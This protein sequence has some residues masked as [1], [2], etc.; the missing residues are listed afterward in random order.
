MFIILILRGEAAGEAST[1][2]VSRV[3]HGLRNLQVSC[4]VL[5]QTE[6]VLWRTIENNALKD[7]TFSVQWL[8]LY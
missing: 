2:T 3:C 6:S 1:I 7:T 4:W 8:Q 5:G